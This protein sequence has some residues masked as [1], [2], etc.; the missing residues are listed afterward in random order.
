MSSRPQSWEPGERRFLHDCRR[1]FGRQAIS[2]CDE[3]EHVR[4]GR[5]IEDVHPH[6][7]GDPF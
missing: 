3:R 5:F 2:C 1:K 4:C 7:V 6:H